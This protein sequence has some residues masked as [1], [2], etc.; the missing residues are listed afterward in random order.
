[1]PLGLPESSQDM[2]VYLKLR[3]KVSIGVNC[4]RF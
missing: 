4:Y 1:M 2:T 3:V